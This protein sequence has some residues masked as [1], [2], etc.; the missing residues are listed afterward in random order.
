MRIRKLV[1]RV[2]RHTLFVG[3][4]TLLTQIGGLIWLLALAMNY[5]VQRRFPIRGL[6]WGIFLVLYTVAT[7]WVVP[8]VAR[9]YFGRVP[10]PAFDNS[11]LAPENILFSFFNRTYVKPELRKALEDVANQLQ[12][13][14][15]GAAI[16]FMDA[17]FPFIDGY[18]LEPHFSHRDGKKVDITFY[19]KDAKTGAPILQNPS[20]QGYGFW[21]EPL[22]NEFDYGAYCVEKGYWYIGYDGDITDWTYDKND[23]VFDAGRTREMLRLLAEHPS[24]GKI[25][26]QPHLTKRLDLE[27]Y[28]KIRFQGCRAARHDDHAHVQLR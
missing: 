22:P 19:W 18:P 2:F 3:F 7:V 28:D 14:Y 11:H 15:P 10:L 12:E 1:F 27:R 8:P 4:L 9:R 20:P 24:I 23:Y 17:N 26:M 13:N 21:V 5:V 25:L 6:R 16:W